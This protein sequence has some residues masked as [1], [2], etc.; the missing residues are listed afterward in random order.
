VLVSA[1]TVYLTVTSRTRIVVPSSSVT[2]TDSS[3]SQASVRARPSRCSDVA[4]HVATT[5]SRR[6]DQ[7][8]SAACS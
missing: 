2:A 3:G 8:A 5:N 7:R 1:T 4:D 6:R